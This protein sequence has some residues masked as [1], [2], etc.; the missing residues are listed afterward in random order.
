MQKHQATLSAFQ[1]RRSTAEVIQV[2]NEGSYLMAEYNERTGS[3]SWQRVL[4]ATQREIIERWLREHYPMKV[5]QPAAAKPVVKVV[6]VVKVK[7]AK[8]A[9][10]APRKAASARRPAARGTARAGHH[11][12]VAR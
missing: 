5:A 11:K 2:Y 6:K 10:A 3:V 9:I 1:F 4:L 8:K 7:V 12:R